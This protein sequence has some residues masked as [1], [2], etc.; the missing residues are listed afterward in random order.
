[1]KSNEGHKYLKSC[2]QQ[3]FTEHPISLRH[4]A[5]SLPGKIM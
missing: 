4:H 3:E 2:H 5:M 1:M